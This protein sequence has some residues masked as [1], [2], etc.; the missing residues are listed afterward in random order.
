MPEGLANNM[1]V[2]DFR[3]LVR[4]VMAHPFL[5]DVKIAGPFPYGS[6]TGIDPANVD[7]SKAK[8]SSPMVGVPGASCCRRQRS[9]GRKAAPSWRLRS[10]ALES[11]R[12]RVQLGAARASRF[13]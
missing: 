12:T 9:W 4:Y 11:M 10:I 5:T 8:W 7:F 3:D 6:G 1:T 13:G 2:Q